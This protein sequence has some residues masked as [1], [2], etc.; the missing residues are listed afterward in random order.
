MDSTRT[1]GGGWG[2]MALKSFSRGPD[3][4]SQV[5]A[6]PHIWQESCTPPGQ[7]C[8]LTHSTHSWAS[9]LHLVG[10]CQGGGLQATPALPT[11]PAQALQYATAVL[12]SEVLPTGRLVLSS[13]QETHDSLRPPP[14]FKSPQHNTSILPLF[15]MTG[16]DLKPQGH[17]HSYFGL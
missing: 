15:A 11:G 10:Q 13:P 9:P 2:Y 12:S 4:G 8:S 7:C 1:L 16:S 14:L 5:R 6:A 17:L 3:L